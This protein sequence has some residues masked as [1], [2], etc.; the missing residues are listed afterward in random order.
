MQCEAVD[1]DEEVLDR[2]LSFY[3]SCLLR[4]PLLSFLSSFLSDGLL[5]ITVQR[6]ESNRPPDLARKTSPTHPNKQRKHTQQ[7]EL[8]A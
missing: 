8:A 3:G 1:E 2:C 6:N 4:F 7:H 5:R